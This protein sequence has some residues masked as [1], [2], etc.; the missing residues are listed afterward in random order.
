MVKHHMNDDEWWCLPGGGVEPQETPEETVLR[1]LEEECCVRG[2]I[3]N[4]TGHVTD[5]SGIE[6]ITFLV[7]IGSQEPHMGSDPE[8]TQDDQI[9]VDLRWLTLAQ[10][11]ERDRAYLWA[12]GL[13]N[14]PIFLDEVSG[15]GDDLSYP[16]P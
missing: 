11:P 10:I 1:E 15:W 7:E 12:A 6:T 2:L 4:Q 5:G 9:L 13:M 3:V 8:F 14:I 16:T